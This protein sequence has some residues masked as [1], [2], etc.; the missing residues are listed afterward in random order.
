[1]PTGRSSRVT[2]SRW[3]CPRSIIEAISDK[4]ILAVAL[5][6]YFDHAGGW[7]SFAERACHALTNFDDSRARRAML[8]LPE[9]LLRRNH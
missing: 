5:N 9:T 3:R 8:A 6:S 7:H 1:M 2:R 4:P